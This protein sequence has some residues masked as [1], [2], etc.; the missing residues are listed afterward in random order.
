MRVRITLLTLLLALTPLLGRC[1][2]EKS[3]LDIKRISR[4][5][6]YSLPLYHLNELPLDAH[7]S[8]NAFNLFISSLDPSHTYFLQTDIDEFQTESNILYKQLRKGD[9]SFAHD[10]FNVLLDPALSDAAYENSVHTTGFSQVLFEFVQSVQSS[11][12]FGSAVRNSISH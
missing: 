10:V 5:V 11:Q 2:L 1:E 6:A 7:I 9:I 3:E 4:S 8:T 12:V